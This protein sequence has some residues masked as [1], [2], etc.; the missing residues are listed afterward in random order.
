MTTSREVSILIAASEA[1]DKI[2]TSLPLK[3]Q[4]RAAM[5]ITKDFWMDTD[6]DTRFR[7][8]DWQH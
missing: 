4:A 2:D 8:T 5:E 7:G 6:E 3:D 1:K